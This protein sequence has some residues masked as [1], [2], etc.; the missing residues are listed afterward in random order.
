MDVQVIQEL[1]ELAEPVYQFQIFFQ[2]QQ[3]VLLEAVEAVLRDQVLH[4]T[5]E[6][7]LAD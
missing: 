2:E 6:Q 1:L 7:V 3:F 4:Q 5:Q